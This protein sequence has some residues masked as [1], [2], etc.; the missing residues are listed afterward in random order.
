V[1]V[2][3][4]PDKSGALKYFFNMSA[5]KGPGILR[6]LKMFSNIFKHPINFIKLILNFNWANNTVILLVMQT[7][8]NSM[9]IKWKRSIF[10]GKIKFDNR[11]NKKVPAFIQAGQDVLAKYAEVIDGVPQNII[12]EVMFNTPTTAHILGGCPMG[13]SANEGVIDK[14][15][16]VHAYPNMFIT[17]GSVIQGNLGVNPSLTITAQAEYAMSLIKSKS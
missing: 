1:E 14:D 9:K 11:G 4:F 12:L 16:Q 2:V 17:D 13:D 8:D 6:S 10:G 5:G 3:K 15:F 7:I